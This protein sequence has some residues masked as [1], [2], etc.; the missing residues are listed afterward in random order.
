MSMFIILCKFHL[1][2]EI[3][4][5]KNLYSFQQFYALAI[6]LQRAVTFSSKY[7]LRG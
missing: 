1:H 7:E 6:Y 3:R 4:L 5:C 2:H